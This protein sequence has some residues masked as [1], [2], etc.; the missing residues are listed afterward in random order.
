[1]A[2]AWAIVICALKH[3]CEDPPTKVNVSEM[4]LDCLLVGQEQLLAQKKDNDDLN[5]RSLSEKD[6]RL[7][8]V[9]ADDDRIDGMHRTPL[10]KALRLNISVGLQIIILSEAVKMQIALSQ[11]IKN[12]DEVSR[13][14]IW[15]EKQLK[16]L[17]I[18]RSIIPDQLFTLLEFATA[19]STD[20]KEKMIG[21]GK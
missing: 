16:K 14:D 21:L 9:S 19:A 3:P 6:I 1:M 5:D 13:F 8:L 18:E 2:K 4:Y 11:V 15:L 12:H 20:D 10:E 17:S 7:Q